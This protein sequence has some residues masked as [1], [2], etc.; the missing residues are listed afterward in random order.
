MYS[1]WHLAAFNIRNH[2]Q[3]YIVGRPWK[4]SVQK[5]LSSP[6]FYLEICSVIA[7]Q[8]FPSPLMCSKEV[9]QCQPFNILSVLIFLLYN[10]CITF[11][12]LL[13][14][15]CSFINCEI[16]KEE[17]EKA[18]FI[19]LY[20]GPNILLCIHRGIQEFF[21][22]VNICLQQPQIN[23]LLQR[24]FYCLYLLYI[25]SLFFVNMSRKYVQMPVFLNVL[26]IFEPQMNELTVKKYR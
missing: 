22:L 7:R 4:V 26:N 10:T 18:N 15:Y 25:P 12:E 19:F 20:P 11:N 13:N 17:E 24:W 16:K 3:H 6:C 8:L 5:S 14:V 9:A 23:Q 21:K 1:Y 2:L